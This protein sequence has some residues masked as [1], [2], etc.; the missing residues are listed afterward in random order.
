M[1]IRGVKPKPPKYLALVKG[2]PVP[3]GQEDPADSIQD[4]YDN[5]LEPPRRLSGRQLELW[6]AIIRKASW[7]TEFDIPRAFMWVHMHTEF[8]R[9]PQ[10]MVAGRIAQLRALG[11]ELG[12]DPSSRTRIGAEVKT[13]KAK[14]DPAEKFFV[15]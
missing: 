12:L 1:A 15:R 8:E 10:K 4:G 2:Q 9:K 11:S 7:L 13:P 6:N 3:E 14:M 5:G